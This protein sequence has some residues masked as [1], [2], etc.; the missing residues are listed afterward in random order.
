MTYITACNNTRSLTHWG[1]SGIKPASSW[2]LCLVLNPLTTV[3]TLVY[4]HL[5]FL[6]KHSF[7]REKHKTHKFKLP[8]LLKIQSLLILNYETIDG[9]VNKERRP[10]LLQVEK[11]QREQRGS[12]LS[13]HYL[14]LP[15]TAKNDRLKASLLSPILS[16]FFFATA[17]FYR[18]KTPKS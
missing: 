8:C 4:P 17:I 2:R 15:R 1:R 5:L 13:W 16:S 10:L 18:C 9:Q 7:G 3:G 6:Y 14:M 12:L 11:G